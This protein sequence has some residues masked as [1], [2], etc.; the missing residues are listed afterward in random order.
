MARGVAPAQTPGKQD[1]LNNCA[2]CHGKDG[3][4]KGP[5]LYV[6]PGIQPPDLTTLAKRNGGVFPFQ[7]TVDAIDGRKGI[8]SHKRFDM[9]FWGVRMQPEG[10]EFTPESD[11]QVKGRIN[12]L[13]HYVESMQVR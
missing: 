8:P 5:D 1:Y 9:P 4:G 13:V 2:G 3:K 6:V 12:A 10:R 11:A 7:Q